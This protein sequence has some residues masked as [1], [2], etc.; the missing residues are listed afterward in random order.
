[1]STR[2]VLHDR[3]RIQDPVWVQASGTPLD[4]SVNPPIAP[5]DLEEGVFLPRQRR[6]LI[7]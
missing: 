6:G 2:A 3:D 5:A 7:E 1:M 4:C